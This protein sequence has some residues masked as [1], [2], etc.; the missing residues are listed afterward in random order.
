MAYTYGLFKG[1]RELAAI[2][3][4]ERVA[5]LSGLDPKAWGRRLGPII[6]GMDGQT[7]AYQRQE[8]MKRF[9]QETTGFWEL[10]NHLAELESKTL[11]I[12][13][14]VDAMLLCTIVRCDAG[15][16]E[17]TKSVTMQMGGTG[18]VQVWTLSWT[19]TV[20]KK[21][22]TLRPVAPVAPI[23]SKDVAA[24]K[25]AATE[26]AKKART[27]ATLKQA[28]KEVAA[29]KEAAAKA[30]ARAAVR[31]AATAAAKEHEGGAF[32]STPRADMRAMRGLLA[33]M[34]ALSWHVQI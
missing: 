15:R 8:L 34:G 12:E 16:T 21:V 9:M 26:A 2:V 17:N 11:S 33:E 14:T 19:E 4:R 3:E 23:A 28:A 7:E 24:W 30:A 18:S 1:N 20:G 29:W 22:Y 32:S 25:E 31:E 27:E 6:A 5:L 10:V 13:C